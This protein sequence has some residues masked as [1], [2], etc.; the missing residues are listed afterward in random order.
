MIS[1]RMVGLGLALALGGCSGVNDAAESEE[2]Q[3]NGAS[4]PSV[5]SQLPAAPVA[6]SSSEALSEAAK[7]NQAAGKLGLLMGPGVELL[8]SVELVDGGQVNFLRGEE[9]LISVSQIYRATDAAPI[10]LEDARRVGPAEVFR[11]LAPERAVPDALLKLESEL[12]S[13]LDERR[14]EPK[15]AVGSAAESP[16]NTSVADEFGELSAPVEGQIQ[17]AAID[18]SK[19]PAAKFKKDIC[20]NQSDDAHNACKLTRTGNGKVERSDMGLIISFACSYRGSIGH[21][22]D[23]R[24]WSDWKI[25]VDSILT[26]GWV[27]G[28]ISFSGESVLDGDF[29]FEA[30][31]NRASG[32]GWN[33]YAWFL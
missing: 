32:D 25:L 27:Q 17:Q 29:D 1:I 26:P 7:R 19:C 15:S 13:D 30:I 24:H 21:R 33:Q 10:D 2:G 8:A 16:V 18:D 22:L 23:Y 3:P 20:Q 6:F 5:D 4:A 28:S 12:P 31:I 9:G 11:R 14:F